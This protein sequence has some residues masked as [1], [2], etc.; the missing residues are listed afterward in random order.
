MV[1]VTVD[2]QIH[3]HPHLNLSLLPF[4]RPW[5][6]LHISWHL[7]LEMQGQAGASP[8]RSAP[9]KGCELEHSR[10][11]S[12]PV[13]DPPPSTLSSLLTAL[14]CLLSLQEKKGQEVKKGPEVEIPKLDKLLNLV[15]EPENKTEE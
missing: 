6:L 12:F 2:Q 8:C 9:S 4:L 3:S 10:P 14:P 1:C 7:G 15:R 5:G 13:P 11:E